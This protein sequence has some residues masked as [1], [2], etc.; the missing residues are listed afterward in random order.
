MLESLNINYRILAR[1][2]GVNNAQ[3]VELKNSFPSIPA[4]YLQLIGEVTELELEYT[5]GQY[6][7]I[8]GP[9]GCFEMDSGYDISKYI[10]GAIPIG[11]DGGGRVIFYLQDKKPPGLYHVGYGN[12]DA[13]DA[14]YL[15][16]NLTAL[17]RDAIGIDTF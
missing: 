7:R 15:A 5:T 6:I 12:L 11:D 8:W 9:E 14:V 2:P 13:N 10:P 3:V 17:L 16:P 4:E 1:Q